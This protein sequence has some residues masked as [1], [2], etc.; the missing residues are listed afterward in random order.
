MTMPD[1]AALIDAL[2]ALH[3]DLPRKGPGDDALSRAMVERVRPLLPSLPRAAD[4]GCGNGAAA[5]LLAETL[6][7]QVVALDFSAAFVAELA[8]RL[9]AQPPAAGAVHP[10]VGDMRDPGLP[11]GGL[12]L[13]WSEGAAYAVG[14]EEALRVWRPLMAPGGVL[15]LS[16]CVWFTP[17]PPEPARA[18]WAENYPGMGHM[19]DLISA[20][21]RQGWEFLFAD[22]LPAESWWSGYFTP[23]QERLRHLEAEAAPGSPLALVIADAWREQDIFR[24]YSAHFGY[25]FLVARAPAA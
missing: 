24:R 19:G 13:L 7:A 3:R 14:T 5:L 9:A 17:D 21:H 23:L 25:G 6:G 11:P 10:V 16:E 20:A 4:L 2:I 8:A 18:F 15:V 12:D 22:R 1:D